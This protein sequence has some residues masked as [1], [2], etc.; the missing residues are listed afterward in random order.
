MS[1]TA[2]IEPPAN[3]SPAG[4]TP[5]QIEQTVNALFSPKVAGVPEKHKAA[6]VAKEQPKEKEQEQ[7]KSHEES[8]AELRGKYE[9]SEKAVKEWEAKYGTRDAE[10][11]KTLEE[12]ESYKKN[13][14]PKEFEEKL[15]AAEKRAAEY[16]QRLRTV[17]LARD[18]EFQAKYDTPMQVA[19]KNMAQMLVDS[20]ISQEEV[21]SAVRNWNEGQFSEWFDGMQPAQKLRAMAQYQRV[22]DLDT[23]KQAELSDSERVSQNLSKQREEQAQAM[24]KQYL[25]NLINARKSV[26]DKVREEQKDKGITDEIW[27]QTEQLLDGAIGVNGT[28][29]DPQSVMQVIANTHILSHHFQRVDAERIKL[30]EELE[31]VKKTLVERDEFIAK[32]SGSTVVPGSLS[33]KTTD[34]ADEIVNKLLKPQ[35][36]F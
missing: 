5:E 35:V 3:L 17:D 20:G 28:K 26:L 24:Q 19:M 31:A 22:I 25:D 6:P 12:F 8:F 9:A 1:E 13:P 32:Q 30:A 15:I 29:V 4:K 36:K 2:T 14:I 34:N 27:K 33:T 7:K 11:K 10:A 18:P 16:Q 23:A 21:T